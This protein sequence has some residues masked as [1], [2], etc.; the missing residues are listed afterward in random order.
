MGPC[1]NSSYQGN[2]NI[3]ENTNQVD[4]LKLVRPVNPL[5]MTIKLNMFSRLI[6]NDTELLSIDNI[7]FSQVPQQKAI[8]TLSITYNLK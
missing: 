2:R 6:V 3:T 4:I 7:E 5:Q 8:A 1:R